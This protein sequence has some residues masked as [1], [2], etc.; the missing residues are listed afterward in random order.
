MLMAASLFLL[1]F[2]KKTINSGKPFIVWYRC[3]EPESP[4]RF[5][6]R[7]TDVRF[8]Q[9]QCGMDVTS[10]GSGQWDR[11]YW[12]LSNSSWWDLKCRSCVFMFSFL[13]FILV[14]L[15]FGNNNLHTVLCAIV[16]FYLLQLST[17]S[18]TSKN[19]LHNTHW[20]VRCVHNNIYCT[21]ITLQ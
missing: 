2:A 19:T 17:K 8:N 21:L 20:D 15:L 18:P 3:W 5:F 10:S 4:F 16:I 11:S 9:W 14:P 7:L 1:Y 6:K 12:S 13:I